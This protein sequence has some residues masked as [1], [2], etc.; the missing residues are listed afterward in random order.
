MLA[1]SPGTEGS[2]SLIHAGIGAA[3]TWLAAITL[4]VTRRREW[5]R[6]R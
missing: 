2:A 1:P 5:A 3:L 4:L 6:H